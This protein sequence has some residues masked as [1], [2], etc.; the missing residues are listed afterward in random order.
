M[1]GQKP[2]AFGIIGSYGY[3]IDGFFPCILQMMLPSGSTSRSRK[4]RNGMSASISA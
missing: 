3:E 4:D 2:R 1:G